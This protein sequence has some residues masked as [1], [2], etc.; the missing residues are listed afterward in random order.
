[1]LQ[2]RKAERGRK[3]GLLLETHR[4]PISKLF[5]LAQSKVTHFARSTLHEKENRADAEDRAEPESLLAPHLSA[6]TKTL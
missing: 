3:P 1:M 4:F 5:V 2:D 6:G